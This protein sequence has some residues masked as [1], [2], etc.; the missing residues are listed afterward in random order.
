MVL[1]RLPQ[2][3][4]PGSLGLEEVDN[5]IGDPDELLGA[6][7]A[8]LLNL[9]LNIST[10]TSAIR[11]FAPWPRAALPPAALPPAAPPP[12]ARP[13]NKALPVAAIAPPPAATAPPPAAA[14]ATGAGIVGS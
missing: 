10:P 3:C 12:R 13:P 14:A 6:G 9:L 8:E 1:P 5:G 4:P 2:L 11:D 7:V